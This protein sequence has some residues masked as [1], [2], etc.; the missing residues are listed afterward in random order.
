MVS[1]DALGEGRFELGYWLSSEEHPPATL[2]AH[3][4]EAEARGFRTAMM[5]DHFAPWVPQQ[6]NSGFVWSV[7][8]AIATSTRTLRVGTGVSAVVHRV[9]PLVIAHAAATVEALMPGRFFL[10]WGPA[11]G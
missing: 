2:V 10:G 6:G 8:G 1:T 3:A 4:V 7:L 9:H 5:S 11:S